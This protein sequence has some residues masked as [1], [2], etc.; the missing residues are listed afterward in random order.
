M[1]TTWFT[2]VNEDENGKLF[3]ELPEDLLK[4]M[5]WTENTALWWEVDDT[6]K[7]VTL[8]AKDPENEIS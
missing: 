2:D 4:S 7:S 8:T 1:K 3:I 5:G 6:S